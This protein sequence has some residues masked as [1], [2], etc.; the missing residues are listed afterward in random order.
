MD[1]PCPGRAGLG[2]GRVGLPSPNRAALGPHPSEVTAGCRPQQPPHRGEPG[3]QVG[4]G[5]A[6]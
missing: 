4:L 6:L 1:C 2:V 3:L 5:F